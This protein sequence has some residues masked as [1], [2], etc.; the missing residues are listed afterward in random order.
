L[1]DDAAIAAYGHPRAFPV[2]A[3]T[4]H[5]HSH[6]GSQQR[7]ALG[8]NQFERPI[9]AATVIARVVRPTQGAPVWEEA[10]QVA[11]ANL[12]RL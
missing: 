2:A 7:S 8:L 11:A 3:R 1:G 9:K 10:D 4:F 6:P 5:I 12:G